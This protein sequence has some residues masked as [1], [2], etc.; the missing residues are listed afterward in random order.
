MTRGSLVSVSLLKVVVLRVVLLHVRVEV[1]LL[2]GGVAA[3]H[4][5]E[6]GLLAALEAQ[7]AQHVL[8]AAVHLEAP[9]TGRLLLAEGPVGPVPLV[10]LAVCLWASLR[11]HLQV[12]RKG[13]MPPRQHVV[14]T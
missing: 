11:A 14:T 6:L 9:R 5:P 8:P 10:A 7:V 3:V 13:P 4:A 2:L 12:C 1:A